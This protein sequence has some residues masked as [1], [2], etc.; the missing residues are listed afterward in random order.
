M[1]ASQRV[2][3]ALGDLTACCDTLHVPICKKSQ[4]HPK[5][6]RQSP[7]GIQQGQ[8]L[9]DSKSQ[10]WVG[11]RGPETSIHHTVCTQLKAAAEISF[12]F[13]KIIPQGKQLASE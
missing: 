6:G 10:D 4:E 7:L 9:Q 13:T 8:L 5:M 1:A 3:P 2:G 11:R 12:S